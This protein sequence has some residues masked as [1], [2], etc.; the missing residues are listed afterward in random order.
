MNIIKVFQS[1]MFDVNN[2]ITRGNK[3]LKKYL[4]MEPLIQSYVEYVIRRKNLLFIENSIV[5]RGGTL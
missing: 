4:I 1:V 2:F 3:T 5:P